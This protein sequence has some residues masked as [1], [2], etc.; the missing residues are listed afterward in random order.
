[1]EPPRWCA[2]GIDPGKKGGIGFLYEGGRAEAYKLNTHEPSDVAK[3]LPEHV[4][5]LRVAVT[6]EKVSSMVGWGRRQL[7]A[8]GTAWGVP[9]GV[10]AARGYPLLFTPPKT[11]QA[12]VSPEGVPKDKKQRKAYFKGLVEERWGLKVLDGPADALLMAYALAKER[13]YLE[14]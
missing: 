11:W 9:Q 3:A 4:G 1:M 12:S 6:V 2:I 8:F 14:G 7:F 5:A 13:F 10:V